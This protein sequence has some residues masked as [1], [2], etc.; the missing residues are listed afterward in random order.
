[1][2][3][4]L[5]ASKQLYTALSAGYPLVFAAAAGEDRGKTGWM[6]LRRGV[7]V[8]GGLGA[9]SLIFDLFC[10]ILLIEVRD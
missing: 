9:L 3:V 10:L 4:E 2:G 7:F 6:G 5:T 1:M 8:G